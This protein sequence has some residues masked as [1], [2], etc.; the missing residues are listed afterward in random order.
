MRSVS[1]ETRSSLFRSPSTANVSREHEMTLGTIRHV[2]T[3][4]ISGIRTRP[5]RIQTYHILLLFAHFHVSII[6]HFSFLV[7][8]APSVSHDEDGIAIQYLC[9]RSNSV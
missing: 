7:G 6:S 4:W 3:S 8:L 2:L 5:I 9:D 1:V